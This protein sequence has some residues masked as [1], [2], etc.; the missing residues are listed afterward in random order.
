MATHVCTLSTLL[1]T[2]VRKKKEETHIEKGSADMKMT[3][4][5]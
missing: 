1:I 5:V 2:K 4:D 3:N